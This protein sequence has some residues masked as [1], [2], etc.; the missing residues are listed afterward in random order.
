MAAPLTKLNWLVQPKLTLVYALEALMRGRPVADVV[1]AS[2]LSRVAQALNGALHLDFKGNERF[3]EHFVP[4]S[5]RIDSMR[6][7]LR[8]TLTRIAGRSRADAYLDRYCSH[9]D[10]LSEAGFG[11][12]ERLTRERPILHDELMMQW[13]MHG[14]PLLANIIRWAEPSILVEQADAIVIH[15]VTEGYGTTYPLHNLL[16]VEGSYHAAAA[17]PDVVRLAWQVSLLATDLPRVADQFP[18]LQR[19]IQVSS[20]A[21]VPV[22]LM[23]AQDLELTK[24][25]RPTLEQ[26]LADWLGPS[27]ATPERAEGVWLWWEV[28]R[29]T[30]PPWPT[31]LKTL[32]RLV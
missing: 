27:V 30:R 26:S 3:L 2:K 22:V 1:L 12:L 4:V 7:R 32:E 20:V 25:D 13:K 18:S 5:A 23:A 28:Y 15:P 14:T 31:A 16:C 21:H 6:E 9:L 17:P 24:F 19:S 10:K 8:V 29:D 11:E